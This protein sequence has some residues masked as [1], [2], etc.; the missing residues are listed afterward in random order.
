MKLGESTNQ[1]Y[2]LYNSKTLVCVASIQMASFLAHVCLP[3][4]FLGVISHGMMI[5]KWN[6]TQQQQPRPWTTKGALSTLAGLPSTISATI[7]AVPRAWSLEQKNDQ[8]I[9]QLWHL[10]LPQVMVMAFARGLINFHAYRGYFLSQ[11]SFSRIKEFENYQ[12]KPLPFVPSCKEH[13]RHARH[14]PDHWLPIRHWTVKW[15]WSFK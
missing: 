1:E 11:Y 6:H 2:F 8:Q 10:T 7:S 15:C 12:R 3:Y 4:N 13:I 14:R 5:L 9:L